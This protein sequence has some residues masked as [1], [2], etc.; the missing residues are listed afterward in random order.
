M[1]LPDPWTRVR[2]S[3]A[4]PSPGRSM[5][6]STRAAARPRDL[7]DRQPSHNGIDGS[8]P[9]L[10]QRVLMRFVST[11]R[12]NRRRL[13]GAAL[14]TILLWLLSGTTGEAQVGESDLALRY[15]RPARQWV[16]ALPVGNGRLG[17]MVFGGVARE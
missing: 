15:T 17:A 14:A 8:A 2:R 3:L 13:P 5:E 4:E 12:R 10:D 11:S 6:Y 1:S 9:D 16:E 7:R